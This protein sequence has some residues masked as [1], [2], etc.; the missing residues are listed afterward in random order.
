MPA[1]HFCNN[2]VSLLQIAQVSGQAGLFILSGIVVFYQLIQSCQL[3][4]E[5]GSVIHRACPDIVCANNGFRILPAGVCDLYIKRILARCFNFNRNVL[6][7]TVFCNRSRQQCPCNINL[8][9]VLDTR[10]QQAVFIIASIA[11][12]IDVIIITL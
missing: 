12:N 7:L 4:T 6:S 8:Y 3:R 10:F 9:I 11:G 5:L 1:L 2:P